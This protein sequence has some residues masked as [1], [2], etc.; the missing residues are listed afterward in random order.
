MNFGDYDWKGVVRT[1]APALATAFGTPLMGVATKVVAD[2]LL[3][4]DAPAEITDKMLEQAV[5]AASPDQLIALKQAGMQ[6]EAD[7]A[8]LGVDL[9]RLANEDRANARRREID[10]GDVWTP[11]IL[12]GGVTVGFFGVLTWLLAAGVPPEGGEALLVMLGALGTAWAGIIS[13]FFGSSAG[14]KQKNE[15]LARAEALR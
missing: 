2:V 15:L 6:F 12:A 10:T 11:R 7:M 1:I 5:R 8:K 14:S 9:E 13:Y 3:G 4:E